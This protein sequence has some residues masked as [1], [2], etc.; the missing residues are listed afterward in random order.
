MKRFLFILTAALLLTACGNS[1]DVKDMY[2]VDNEQDAH[3]DTKNIDL[4]TTDRYDESDLKKII[5]DASSQYNLDVVNG[6]RYNIIDK[7]GKGY[8]EAKI[9]FNKQG[10]NATGAKKENIADIIIK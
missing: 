8:A 10:M 5:I 6:I 1:V 2:S 7:D 4:I 3:Q 9:A